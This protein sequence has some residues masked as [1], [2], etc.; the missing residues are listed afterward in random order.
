M[1]QKSASEFYFVRH[2]ETAWSITGQHT[3]KTDLA[4][5]ARGEEQA[6]ALRA[7]LGGLSFAHVFSSPLQRARRTCGIFQWRSTRP[8]AGRVELWR[9]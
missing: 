9:L 3:G 8:G 6:R 5:T 4:L 1:Q 7:R 2:G